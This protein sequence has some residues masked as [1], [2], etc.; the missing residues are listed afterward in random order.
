MAGIPEEHREKVKQYFSR[1]QSITNQLKADMANNG[2]SIALISQ[3]DNSISIMANQIAAD[4]LGFSYYPWPFSNIEPS[5]FEPI[6]EQ[7][8]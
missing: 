2:A 6:G 1:V 7:N 8:G 3:Q 5:H 4:Q